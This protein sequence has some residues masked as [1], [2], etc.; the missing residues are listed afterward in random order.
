[1]HW[2]LLKHSITE[3]RQNRYKG[4]SLYVGYSTPTLNAGLLGRNSFEIPVQFYFKTKI[5]LEIG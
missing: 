2:L 5:R 3:T 1:M 4:L